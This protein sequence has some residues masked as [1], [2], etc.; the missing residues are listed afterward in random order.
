MAK[1][2]LD[3]IDKAILR[4]MLMHGRWANTNQIANAVRI[5]WPTADIHTTCLYRYGYLVKG[6]KGTLTYWRANH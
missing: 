5:A 1:V 3:H 2:A 4:Y 6:K